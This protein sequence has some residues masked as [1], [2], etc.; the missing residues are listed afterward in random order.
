[1]GNSS[2][3]KFIFLFSELSCYLPLSPYMVELPRDGA[4]VLVRASV[5]TPI[6]LVWLSSILFCYWMLQDDNPWLVR[7][8]FPFTKVHWLSWN[9]FEML[10][11]Q[12]GEWNSTIF[13]SCS[14]GP[15][16]PGAAVSSCFRILYSLF[17]WSPVR[18]NLEGLVAAILP[19]TAFVSAPWIP[20]F[21]PDLANICL[22]WHARLKHPLTVLSYPLPCAHKWKALSY[23]SFFIFFSEETPFRTWHHTKL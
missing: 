9:L 1:M 3:Y 2:A 10:L 13:H 23:D 21:Y 5:P 17:V 8:S 4:P 20:G 18:K 19:E 12:H 7:N 14:K 11:R 15:A 22:Q 6:C 16:T